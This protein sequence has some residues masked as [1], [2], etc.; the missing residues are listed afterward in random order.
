MGR[1]TTAAPHAHGDAL[2]RATVAVTDGRR[3]V[4]VRIHRR[5]RRRRLAAAGVQP[6][7]GTER[8]P[9]NCIR[10]QIEGQVG[11]GLD[12][13]DMYLIRICDRDTFRA[14]TVP[15]PEEPPPD[16]LADPMLWLFGR[17]DERARRQQR[18]PPRSRA[19]AAAPGG[20]SRRFPTT[21]SRRSRRSV[22]T[23]SP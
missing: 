4:L 16:R 9:L 10:G 17:P 15:V 2:E 20:A 11:A 5:R 7:D 12:L 13:E 21:A 19:A 6:L 18:Q 8:P 1:W 22:C 23:T 14:F 3:P